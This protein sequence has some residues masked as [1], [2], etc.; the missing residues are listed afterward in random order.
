M[1]VYFAPAISQVTTQMVA[2]IWQNGR[3]MGF[4]IMNYLPSNW[5]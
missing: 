3:L 4:D 1:D 5:I 2:R